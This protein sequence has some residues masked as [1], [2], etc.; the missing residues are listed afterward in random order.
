MFL[1]SYGII[2]DFQTTIVGVFSI[3]IIGIVDDLIAIKPTWKR[4][5]EL[6]SA[7]F[8]NSNIRCQIISFTMFPWNK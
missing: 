3:L 4:L 6:V 7:F 2:S 5:G 1:I 8:L